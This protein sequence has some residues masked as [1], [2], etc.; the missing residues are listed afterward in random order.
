VEQ[1]S[2]STQ[3]GSLD[4]RGE[5]IKRAGAGEGWMMSDVAPGQIR[6]KLFVKSAFVVVDVSY[7]ATT[8]SIDYDPDTTKYDGESV[9]KRYNTYVKRLEQA[10]YE[11][12]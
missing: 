8:F 10:I 3:T 1:Q 6:G 12:P 11:Q 4:K 9:R 2:F 5:Q 7:T